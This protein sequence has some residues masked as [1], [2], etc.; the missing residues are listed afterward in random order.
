MFLL[1]VVVLYHVLVYV[2]ARFWFGDCG[3]EDRAAAHV[4]AARAADARD[5]FLG[6]R[7]AVLSRRNK[8]ARRRP[9]RS[10][11]PQH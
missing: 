6:L 2:L 11:T 10:I 3:A 9:R 7:Q 4:A 1:S 5:Y 8:H